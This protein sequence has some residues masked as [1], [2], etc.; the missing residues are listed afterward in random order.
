M[1]WQRNCVFDCLAGRAGLETPISLDSETAL[2]P[3]VM[4][5]LLPLTKLPV[6]DSRATPAPTIRLFPVPVGLSLEIFIPTKLMHG[7]GGI[8]GFW[9]GFPARNHASPF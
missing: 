2:L 1:D 5:H 4:T 3:V 6:G 7:W 8:A 9:H